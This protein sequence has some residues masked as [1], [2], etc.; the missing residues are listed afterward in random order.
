[1]PALARTAPASLCDP[2]AAPGR[3]TVNLSAG[4]PEQ[5][6]QVGIRAEAAVP[7]SDRVLGCQPCRHQRVRDALHGEGGDW[8]R[9]GVQ[10]RAEEADPRD[11]REAPA[12]TT[13][14]C[15]ARSRCSLAAGLPRPRCRT[16]H[17]SCVRSWPRNRRPQA[18]DGAAQ[19]ARHRRAR[20]PPA[21]RGIDDLRQRRHPSGDVG[22]SGDREQRHARPLVQRGGDVFGVEGPVLPALDVPAGSGPGP[23]Q[24]VGVMIG[25]RRD[26]NV[27]P[28]QLEPVSK[29]MDSLGRIATLIRVITVK[30]RTNLTRRLGAPPGWADCSSGSFLAA[31]RVFPPCGPA[32]GGGSLGRE[33]EGS[34]C[35]WLF[36]V[37][38]WF[39]VRGWREWS[40]K[41]PFGA[42]PAWGGCHDRVSGTGLLK[43][44]D[45]ARRW[46]RLM[47]QERACPGLGDPPVFMA[48]AAARSCRCL[49][50]RPRLTGKGIEPRTLTAAPDAMT[51]PGGAV[52][53]GRVREAAGTCRRRFGLRGAVDG[54]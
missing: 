29:V 44:E 21:V 51:T 35:G 9:L 49:A 52:R 26:H 38:R 43:S 24:Q 50:G 28:S 32:S 42:A 19:A 27:V 15:G 36:G 22:R 4:E 25:R 16:A 23:G 48:A 34:F 18:A 11:R 12:A 39:P 7:Y 14:R 53:I 2:R 17:T 1:M 33:G 54:R 8:Q 30:R 40:R 6:D 31:V 3:G 45:R 20:A 46:S 13:T 41:H 47:P 5:P 37:A 10:V